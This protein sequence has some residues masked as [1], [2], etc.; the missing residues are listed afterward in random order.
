MK[1]SNKQNT[2]LILII[3]DGWGLAEPNK[4][5]AVESAD[6][7]V[8]D[9][10]Y[11][12][13]PHTEL[14]AHGK[15]VGLP[16]NQPGN[17]EAGHMNIGAGRMVLQDSVKINK[18][19]KDGTFEKNPAFLGAV[20]HVKEL[21]SKLH[22]IGLLSSKS[23]PHVDPEHLYNLLKFLEEHKIKKVYLHFFTDGRDSPQYSALKLVR[24]FE[25]K[26]GNKFKI[27]TIIGRFY[28]MDRKQEWGRTMKAYNALVAGEGKKAKSAS[29]AIAASYG[30]GDSDEFIDP[31]IIE[32]N[33]E[34][35]RIEDKDSI[36]F[37]NLRSD[38]AR[39]LSRVFA[40]KNF[41]EE[42]YEFKRVKELKR[43][44][45]VSL[46][47]FGLELDNV[48]TAFPDIDLENTLPMVLRD[49]KQL[50]IAESEKYAHVTY[51]F[52]GGYRD[53][54]DKEKRIM[55]SSPNVRSYDIT[56]AMSSLKIT[57]IVL[58]DLKK[59]KFDFITVNF[60]APDMVGHTGN[61]VASIACCEAVDK[62]VG[63]IVKDYL[64][65]KGTIIITA[66]H[67]NVEKMIDLKTGE[68]FT[69]HTVN[70]VPFVIVNDKLKNKIKLK[71]QGA[72]SDISPTILDLLNHKKPTEM[73]GESLFYGK[74]NL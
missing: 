28:A 32:N 62:C 14:F 65:E 67:G 72:L 33:K 58:E 64:K 16:A 25:K 8:M 69:E 37:F 42:N 9:W 70:K 27:A 29:G 74:I 63:R 48:I 52:N 13:Y 2:P 6:T 46:T 61:L 49:I 22:L 3:L 53:L 15:H 11:K 51:F 38:R 36:I 7:P 17:S 21:D 68:L 12:K 66:D 1:K 31:C 19:I 54:V 47:N 41:N 71:K 60:A 23:S 18:A 34:N 45:F 40:Q 24:A 30:E 5:N 73:N 39:Q 20:R 59:K 55:V 43:I 44:Y 35:S 4:G 10:L 56:P 57:E 50:Y 26:Y